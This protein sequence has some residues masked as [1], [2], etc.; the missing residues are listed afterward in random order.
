MMVN[1]NAMAVP[2]NLSDLKAPVR[3]QLNNELENSN[4]YVSVNW[5]QLV[6]EWALDLK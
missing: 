2:T 3:S 4:K 1:F 6:A 5:L